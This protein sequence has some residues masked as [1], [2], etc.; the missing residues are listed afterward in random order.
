MHS[1]V[2]K[3][4]ATKNDGLPF[5]L[6]FPKGICVSRCFGAPARIGTGLAV[7]NHRDA[8]LVDNFLFWQL[9]LLSFLPYVVILSEAQNLRI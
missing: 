4:A 7:P 2:A 9:P 5:W 8:T 3:P 6:S 1:T